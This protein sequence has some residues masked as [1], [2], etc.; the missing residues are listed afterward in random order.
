MQILSIRK[1]VHKL[2]DYGTALFNG[3]TIQIAVK[4]KPGQRG[5]RVFSNV[6]KSGD[7]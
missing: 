4:K 2:F 5:D 3:A 7:D 1:A 6:E